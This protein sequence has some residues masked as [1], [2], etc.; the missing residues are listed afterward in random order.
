MAEFNPGETIETEEATIEVTV[1]PER[2]L[3]PGRHRFQLIVVD[4]SGNQSEPDSVDV[5]V[6]D[7]ERPT[8]VLEGPG[9]VPFTRSFN[10]SGRRS[11]DTGGGQIV[12]Y[13]WTMMD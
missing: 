10:L 4:D 13:L 5:I 3:R 12:R 1:T 7:N 6:I 8:A 11:T 2:P 9:Q